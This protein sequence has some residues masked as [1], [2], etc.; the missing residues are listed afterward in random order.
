MMNW[1]DALL[2]RETKI[3]EALR[4]IDDGG[5]QAAVV[6]DE[7]DRLLG[8]VTDADVRRGMLRGVSLDASVVEI[9]NPKPKTALAGSSRTKILDL[10]RKNMLRQIPVTDLEGR[11]VGIEIMDDY[12]K[13]KVRE[14]SVVLMAGGLGKRLYPL[15]AD[16]PKP[17]LKVGDKP[18]LEIILD[19]FVKRGFSK[20]FLS[21]NYKAE[22][23][24][25]HFGDGRKWGVD[26]EYLRED[27]R[28]GTAG[29]LSLLPETDHPVIVMNG[30]LLTTVNLDRLLEFHKEK[31]SVATMCVRNYTHEVPFGVITVE[32]HMVKQIEEKPS[33][34]FFV[35]GGIY[36]L[37]PSVIRRISKGA[38]LDMPQ[39]FDDLIRENQTVAA[40]PV[41]EYWLDIGRA[42]DLE[43]AMG[44]V[45]HVLGSEK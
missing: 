33:Y 37:N 3:R 18:I 45:Y 35:N 4:I 32:D 1:K 22:M 13:P 27:R 6:V 25:A 34:N 9:L 19:N 15:T 11:V 24:E 44:D 36:V 5:I 20:F 28:M 41:R 30:D 23:V 29:S 17:L 26:I 40:F 38:Y 39:L 14:N 31:N 12:L 2:R 42:D 43:R 8:I 21:V 7:N 16:C 10:M